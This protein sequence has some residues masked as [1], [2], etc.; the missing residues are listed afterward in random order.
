MG[1][2]ERVREKYIWNVFFPSI[3]HLSLIDTD[4]DVMTLLTCAKEWH[5][6]T[7]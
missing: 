1:V 6:S 3:S 7:L 4:P 2:C 5:T